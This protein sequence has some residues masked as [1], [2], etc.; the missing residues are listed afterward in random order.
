MLT[1]GKLGKYNEGLRPIG[2]K[3]G[4]NF[5]RTSRFTF[6]NKIETKLSLALS[7]VAV[8]GL[9]V[10]GSSLASAQDIQPKRPLAPGI[11][12][13]ISPEPEENE[14]WDGPLPLVEVPINIDN[15]DY[16]PK[17]EAKTATVF[18]KAK[19]VTLRHGI[20]NLEFAFKPMR[21][22]LVDVPQPTGKM[23][24]KLIWYMVYRVKNNGG[25]FQVTE[26]KTLVADAIPHTTYKMTPV[27]ELT[28]GK[29]GPDGAIVKDDMGNP[30]QQAVKLRFIPHF[31]LES[32]E[33]KKEYLDRIIPAALAPIK[34]REFPGEKDLVLHDSISIS[35]V[36]VPLSEE[37]I[38]K[39][40]WG[41]VTWEQI[42]P[43]IDYFTVYT[44][45]LTNAFKFQDPP[46]AFKK[47]S[48]PGTGRKFTTKT[49]QLNFWR[50]G[51]TVEEDEE[52]IR[53]GVRLDGDSDQEK[54]IYS[55]LQ[56]KIFTE[57]GI[58]KPLDH[59][60]IYR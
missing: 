34:A 8:L 36:D 22:I 19:G 33:Y 57:H 3:H 45:G 37:R 54:G 32:K 55:D 24:R 53:Y 7:A 51:D 44:Q 58:D 21:M 9:F 26:E 48:P 10:L 18:E 41:V 4:K 52:E 50:P 5:A 30:V 23:E 60:W 17:F 46:G 59:L 43:R 35:T 27:T 40:V 28:E 2:A 15:L 56:K 1:L 16:E 29:L 12:T 49:L 25:H 11:L 31:V 39:S 47:G 38:D 20:W 6:M 14:T 13:V 42:D